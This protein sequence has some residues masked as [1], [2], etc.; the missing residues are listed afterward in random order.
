MSCETPR[1]DQAVAHVSTRLVG[2]VHRSD[3]TAGNLEMAFRPTTARGGWLADTRSHETLYF[4]SIECGI[5]GPDRYVAFRPRFNFPSHGNAVR[6]V[7]KTHYG[8]QHDMLKF[9]QVVST[10]HYIYNIEQIRRAHNCRLHTRRP[11]HVKVEAATSRR[12]T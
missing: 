7:A 4:H 1:D 10:C 3:S 6:V 8:K 11:R 9:T 2:S 12:R 5:N